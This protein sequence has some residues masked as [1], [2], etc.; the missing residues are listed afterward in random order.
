MNIE[1]KEQTDRIVHE[2]RTILYTLML[3][4]SLISILLSIII[5][6]T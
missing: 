2:L 1:D 6:Y 5:Q 4:L 3:F